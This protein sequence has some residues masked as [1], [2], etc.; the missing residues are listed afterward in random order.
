MPDRT[1]HERNEK[2]AAQ[3][4]VIRYDAVVE[5]LFVDFQSHLQHLYCS[6]FILVC[7]LAVQSVLVLLEMC[8][9]IHSYFLLNANLGGAFGTKRRGYEPQPSFGDQPGTQQPVGR[10]RGSSLIRSILTHGPFRR[11]TSEDTNMNVELANVSE[12][13]DR[14]SFLTADRDL[15]RQSSERAC[16]R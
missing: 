13:L 8:G 5:Y 3:L 11:G 7:N 4:R 9:G 15:K 14:R 12:S 2:R 10:K 16:P 6:A 1:E